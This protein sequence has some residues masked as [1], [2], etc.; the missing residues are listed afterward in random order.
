MRNPKLY[1]DVAYHIYN[2]GV[3]KRCLFKEEADY[4][5]FIYKISKFKKKY[6]IEIISYCLMPN[7]FHLLI[8]AIYKATNVSDFLKSLQL[9][10]ALYFN[11]KY[12]HS[13]HVFEGTFK[14]KTIENIQQLSN[15]INYL[16]QNPVRKKL[17]IRAAQWPYSG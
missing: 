9:S 12:H 14:N 11:S 16:A 1:A 17:V 8:R 7:H 15:V 4:R 3:S 6:N 2:R 13:G 5:L 10:Y